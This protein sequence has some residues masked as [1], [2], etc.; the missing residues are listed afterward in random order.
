M[1]SHSSQQHLA[2]NEKS[3]PNKSCDLTNC[4]S[5]LNSTDDIVYRSVILDSLHNLIQLHV[6]SLFLNKSSQAHFL[7]HL[8]YTS[9]AKLIMTEEKSMPKLN[10]T[11]AIFMY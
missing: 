1:T 3:L 2:A 7:C 8:C 11:K 5:L 10:I 9:Q 6:T 4:H